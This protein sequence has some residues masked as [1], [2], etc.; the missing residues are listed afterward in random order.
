MKPGRQNAILEIIAER[1]IETQHQ[2][3]LAWAERGFKS[4][5]AT[6]SRGIKERLLSKGLDA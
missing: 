5:Q 2:L 6:L 1:D 4:T 3:L